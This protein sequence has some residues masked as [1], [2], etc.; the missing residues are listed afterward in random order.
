MKHQL[1]AVNWVLNRRVSYL[2]LDPGLGK[3]IVAAMVANALDAHV[4]YVCPPFLTQNTDY[5]FTKWTFKKKLHLLPDSM[6]SK[7]NT[8]KELIQKIKSVERSENKILIVDEAHRFKTATTNRSSALFL[9]ILPYFNDCKIVFMSGTPM[10]NSRP[11]ELWPILKGAAP[12]VFPMTKFSYGIKYC[13]GY[14]DTFGWKF[15]G[16]TNK[17]EFKARIFRRFMLR[18]KKELLNLPP[19][20]EGLLT[21]GEDIPPVVSAIEKRVLEHYS[22]Q[23]L[24]EGKIKVLNNVAELHLAS[25]LRLLGEY[26]LKYALPFIQSLLEETKENLLIFAVH[27]KTVEGLTLALKDYDPLVITGDVNKTKR[28]GLVNEFQENPDRRVFIGNIQA[29]GVGFTLTKATRVLF[30]EFSWVDGENQQASD[31]AHRIG[32][33]SSV[34]VQYVVLKDSFDRTRMEVLLRKRS[35]AI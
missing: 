32:Q 14:K 31:R 2:A 8:L 28:Q 15:D 3:T 5:E 19:K 4:F 21:V 35:N 23:D 12:E 24:I 6:L 9:R 1:D 29:C 22:P 10:P 25:Y 7:E 13:G 34:L 33:K 16:F 30:L 11:M 17:Q 18:Q 27:K 20:L 26:K